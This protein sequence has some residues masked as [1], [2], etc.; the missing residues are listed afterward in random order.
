MALGDFHTHTHHSDGL[1]SPAELVEQAAANGVEVLAVTDHDTTAGLA[2]AEAAARSVNVRLIAGVELSANGDAGDDYHIL[3]YFP[4]VLAV[5]ANGKFQE[6]L[7][8]YRVGRQQRGRV[9]LERLAVLR[10]PLDWERILAIAG[11][12]AVGR[13]HIAQAMVERGYVASVREAF[14]RYLHDDGPIAA[15]REKLPPSGAIE[16]IRSAGGVAVL[17]HPCFL[18]DPAAAVSALKST[19]LAGLEV[20][21]KN[22]SQ[23]EISA[24]AALAESTELIASGGS[25]YHGIHDDERDPGDIPFA[26][27]KVQQFVDGLETQWQATVKPEREAQ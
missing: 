11:P 14:D 2:E 10:M 22:L 3:G 19:G 13:P 21:Y 5:L 23:D 7:H 18:P 8:A 4:S 24:F 26:D 6:Q 9:I 27:A 1:L 16:L 25:D 17:A 20:Y 12:A 15:E